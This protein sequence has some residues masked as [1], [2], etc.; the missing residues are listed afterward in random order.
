M[1]HQL[2]LPADQYNT[3]DL[4]LLAKHDPLYAAGDTLNVTLEGQREQKQFTIV[5]VLAESEKVNKHYC[6][7]LLDKPGGTYEVTPGAKE[8]IK[9]VLP[10]SVN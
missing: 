3:I 7:L 2:T 9:V 10:D 8:E 6:I 4:Y 5:K 1:N